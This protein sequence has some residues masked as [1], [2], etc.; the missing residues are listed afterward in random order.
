MTR[1]VRT[2][3][4]S[5][6]SAVVNLSLLI[7]L[8]LWA[9]RSEWAQNQLVP[10]VES[11]VSSAL[12]VQV[13]IGRVDIDLPAY[14]VFTDL[15]M[16]DAQDQ[17]MFG[18]KR[19]KLGFGSFS[20]LH[21]IFRPNEV[22]NIRVSDVQVIEPEA[23]L[24]RSR[25]DSSWN[26]NCLISK[27]TDTSSGKPIQLR[28]AY[29][30]VVIRGG[31]FSMI[32][33]TKS[34]SILA[35]HSRIN[36][37]NLQI[38]AIDGNVSYHL[39][40]DM[41]MYGQV[42]NFSCAETL[43]KQTLAHLSSDYLID[44]KPDPPAKLRICMEG[45]KVLM[46][47]TV[48]DMDAQ[49]EDVRRDTVPGFHPEFSANFRPSRF[50]FQ[51]LNKLLPKPLPMDEPIQIAGY[52]W[53]DMEGIKSDS[54]EIGLMEKTRLRT[55]AELTGYKD[56]ENLRFK[57]GIEEG[58]VSFEELQRFLPGTNVPLKGVVAVRGNINGS[59]DRLRSQRL[60]VRYLGNTH[61]FA[62]ATLMDYTKGDEMLMDIKFKESKFRFDEIKKLL[63][64]MN[65][66][67]WLTRFG[68][69][70]ID[71][72]FL[73]GV[74][75]FVV[76]ADMTSAYGNV[77]SNLHL[78]LPPKSKRIAYDG[79]IQTQAINFVALQAELPVESRYFNFEGRINGSGNAWGKIDAD[80]EGKV[81]ASDIQGYHIDEI[82][83]K[84]LK[85]RG[86]KITGEVDV[87]DKQGSASVTVDLDVPDSSQHFFVVGDV[88]QVD[89]AH[90]GI[91][92]SDSV[93]M[94]AIVN[95]NL[96]GKNLEDYTGK[97]KFLQAG[98]SR[99]GSADS[100]TLRNATLSS[101]LNDRGEHTV[102][103]SSSM[104]DMSLVGDFKYLQA[105]EVMSDLAYEARLFL[106]N[107]D[108]LTMSYY[109]SKPEDSLAMEFR[110]TIRTKEELNHALA[111][112]QI[113]LYI[114]PKTQMITKFS[115]SLLDE[116]EVKITADSMAYDS[117]GMAGNEVF[118]QLTK[119]GNENQFIG[120]ADLKVQR[121][122]VSEDLRFN[123]VVFQ[124]DADNNRV[125][126]HLWA[127]Q[128][129]IGNKY[130]IAARSVF[131][132]GGE[133]KSTIDTVSSLI[134]R[135]KE[136][137]FSDGSSIVH[138]Y[139]K[140]PSL[141]RVNTDSV[142]SRYHL[143]GLKLRCGQQEIALGGVISRD[144]TDLMNIDI[145]NL[146]I[147]NLL[148]VLQSPEDIDGTLKRATFGTWNLLSGQPSVYGSGEI[149][150][151]RYK[152]VDSIGLRFYGG[153][154]YIYGPD[155]AGMR[156]EVG[157]WGQ[158]S[159]ITK[160]WYNVKN[161]SL[162]FDAD[163][164][165][166]QL[167]WVGPFV[168]GILS[169][170]HGRVALD[171]FKVRGTLFKPEL[172]GIARFTNTSFKV[173]YL[174]N[175]FRIGDNQLRFDHERIQI[176]QIVVKDTVDGSAEMNGNVFYNDERGV[177]LDLRMGKVKD[178]RFMDTRKKDNDV[179]YGRVIL[180]GDSARVTGLA[181]APAIEAWVNT[182]DGS[183]LD[184]PISNYT[185]AN[186]L[187]FVKFIQR[188]DTLSKATKVDYGGM[189]MTLNV[190]ARSNA[191]VRLIF[192]EFVGDIIE[193]RG[194]GNIIVKLDEAGDFNMFGA[195]AVDEGDYHFTMENVL[196]KKFTVTR[197]GRITW[198]GDPYDAL[199]DLDAV[200]QVNADLS[201][202]L[203]TS[204]SGNRVP[205]EIVMHMKGSLMTP[206]ITLE[207]RLQMTE[208]DVFGLATFFQGIQYD[209]QELNKQVVSLL[210]FRRFTGQ[211]AGGGAA[212]ANVTS[213]I[214]EL[215]SNQVNHWLSQSFNDPKIGVELGSSDFKDVQLALRASLFN[216]RVTV[217]RNGTIVGNTRGAVSLGDLIVTIK[218]LPKPDTIGNMDPN[219]GQLVM[220]IFNREDASITNAN[221]VTRGTGMFYKKDFDRLK[222]LIEK[223][224]HSMRKEEGVELPEQGG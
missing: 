47:R 128:D 203:G 147:H 56:P 117:I 204:S 175:V 30:E 185:S 94:S 14:A 155:F 184:I 115:H 113:P 169:D 65:L 208:Q 67:L 73:G 82:Y 91:M 76:N 26:Y 164:S 213:S 58:T 51:N 29:P 162:H 95:I 221:N 144:R 152:Q 53:G 178:L 179:F 86:Y 167:A 43:A 188:G 59:L 19:L 41:S 13:D 151:F 3:F 209:Q 143:R 25:R 63:P 17:P 198:N 118:F 24:Y 127:N 163:S 12:G 103:L 190:N 136:W 15:S 50:D 189:T 133:I 101:K 35:D 49:L 219:A 74:N 161:D 38:G 39:E 5:L 52:L 119:V 197:G 109:E 146:S 139:E 166:L 130:Y 187:E 28:M 217:E 55:S 93:F 168:E 48:L 66:P 220:E 75:D 200:Y 107:K 27:S 176:G 216:D 23:H 84:E 205:V 123:D 207:L 2:I 72:K 218:V 33:S 212:A 191:R 97:A 145:R 87:E 6:R 214:S 90:Y 104:A 206:E 37:S 54:L 70:G 211:A 172:E 18:V 62:D 199:V 1:T 36:F 89:M 135:Q 20:L 105:I 46:G 129:K 96:D 22:Q 182:G 180:D 193:A 210:M 88:K 192:D 116:L 111:F 8:A 69:C 171:H 177:R 7:L 45:A 100:L 99:R 138:L 71:G 64:D 4:R 57:L 77:S 92:P 122:I 79:W 174:N 42:R 44:I 137:K 68:T 195:Y 148:E 31:E 194:D 34:D 126:Y 181:S 141:A 120:N 21:F 124:P 134:I 85:I 83:T 158:D 157:H 170:I 40:P 9:L 201:A 11:A 196:N 110:D 156:L 106:K 80:I 159:V 108:S 149:V 32:D 142:I 78:T 183:W 140:P 10:L 16:K 223:R 173:D 131:L 102:K 222:D 224:K 61:L 81:H 60:E 160:G 165:S 132:D 98:L 114:K 112:L 154:P 202:I 150:N 215:V 153:W 186:R 121:L 125:N